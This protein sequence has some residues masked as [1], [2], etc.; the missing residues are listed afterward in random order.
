ML[1]LVV[2]LSMSLSFHKLNTPGDIFHVKEY[3]TLEMV[4]PKNNPHPEDSTR[5]YLGY[6]R[7][8]LVFYIQMWQKGKINASSRKRDSK[9]LANQAEDAVYLLI[10]TSEDRENAYYIGVNPLGTI[11]DKVILSGKVAEWDGDIKVKTNVKKNYWDALIFIPFKDLSYAKSSWGLQIMRVIVQKSEIQLLYPTIEVSPEQTINFKLDFN[12]I[13]SGR[14]YNLYLIPSFRIEHKP[15]EDPVL[16]GGVTVR[17]KQGA[18]TLLDFTYKPDF[19]EVDV[20]LIDI[21]LSRLLI[22]YPEK[23]P[24]FVEGSSILKS[25]KNLIRTRNIAYPSYGLKF[26]TMQEK[27]SFGTWYI[28]DDSLGTVTFTRVNF[29]PSKNLVIGSLLNANE[30]GYN[31]FS[32]DLTFHSSKLHLN[33]SLQYSRRMDKESNFFQAEVSR[34]ILKGLRLKFLYRDIDSCFISPLNYLNLY[35]D[36]IRYYLGYVNFTKFLDRRTLAKTFLY[37]R[38]MVDKYTGDLYESGISWYF[39]YARLP[40]ATSIGL[41]SHDR[42]YLAAYLKRFG[43]KDTKDKIITLSLAYQVSAWKNLYIEFPFGKYLGGNMINPEIGGAISIHNVNLGFR[44]NH[45]K[46]DLDDLTILQIYGEVPLFLKHTLLKPYVAYR[47]DRKNDQDKLTVNAVLSY[48]PS[49]F[50]GIFFAF[51]R[52]YDVTNGNLNVLSGKEVFKVQIGTYLI[53]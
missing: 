22:N 30:I 27:S 37:G 47:M 3:K 45:L 33:T 18:G 25:P 8:E 12:F 34:D 23:R 52:T 7:K 28:K 39:T 32:S 51:N 1:L 44:V 17:F 48:Q 4:T 40:F 11:M 38:Y 6:T 13:K 36:G 43:I 16:K 14:N 15:T 42:R 20:D 29:S 41:S 9:A 10:S 35:F 53:R 24:F 19:S 2:A 46:S 5:V 26:Y 50:S 31:L 21:D 49:A